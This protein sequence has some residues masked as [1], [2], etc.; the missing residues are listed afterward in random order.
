MLQHSHVP[1][2]PHT[3]F[4]HVTRLLS[5]RA[6]NPILSILWFISVSVASSC[7]TSP[8]RFVTVRVLIVVYKIGFLVV[9]ILILVLAKLFLR[10]LLIYP[11][12]NFLLAAI[13]SLIS[14]LV[15]SIGSSFYRVLNSNLGTIVFLY[16]FTYTPLVCRS[17]QSFL[18]YIQ[19]QFLK[20]YSVK[21]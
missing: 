19:L 4:N 3:E 13:Y 2:F 7:D 5:S 14:S 15:H 21:F 20:I 6:P 11:K 1:T 18:I 10:R 12:L 16:F 8:I 9:L 17:I